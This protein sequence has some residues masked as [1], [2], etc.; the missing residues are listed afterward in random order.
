[1]CLTIPAKVISIKDGK[2]DAPVR[3]IIVEDSRGERKISA[4]S[5][6]GLKVGDWVLYTL[7]LAV[8][9]VSQGEAKEIIDLLEP[10]REIDLSSLSPSFTSV[11]AKSFSKPL[12]RD[13][14]I[15][16]LST[17]N[18]MEME[19]LFSEANTLRQT[20]L[21]DFFCIHGIIEFS[22]NCVRSCHYC[23]LDNFLS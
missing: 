13:D 23:G 10:R 6:P 14:I 2:P 17:E 18:E 20:N 4:I 9:Q 22:S 11:L 19:A 7:D 12:N 3:E 16:L 5:M 1:M 21:H 15:G 8:R